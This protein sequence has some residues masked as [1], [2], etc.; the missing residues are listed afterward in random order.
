MLPQ[1]KANSKKTPRNRF[2]DPES[3]GKLHSSGSAHAFL[4]KRFG[5]SYLAKLVCMHAAAL[6]EDRLSPVIPCHLA[7]V[8]GRLDI[9]PIQ[10]GPSKHSLPHTPRNLTTEIPPF[11]I[12]QSQAIPQA[13]PCP[14]QKKKNTQPT[15]MATKYPKDM[16][17]S[18]AWPC[19]GTHRQSLP[20]Q[21]G[22]I[23]NAFLPRMDQTRWSIMTA[24]QRALFRLL[25]QSRALYTHYATGVPHCDTWTSIDEHWAEL[26]KYNQI[27]EEVESRLRHCLQGSYGDLISEDA[28]MRNVFDYTSHADLFFDLLCREETFLFFEAIVSKWCHFA[29]NGFKLS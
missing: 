18:A 10:K 19:F 29:E 23:A 22:S 11:L 20:A 7:H 25:Q 3:C 17:E 24:I 9:T 6:W 28:F 15:I 13:A 1:S 8:Q 27:W 14:Q 16:F 12:L 5:G 21:L 2:Q 4:V 26:V